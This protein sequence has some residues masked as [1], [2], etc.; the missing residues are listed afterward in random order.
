MTIYDRIKL[1]REQQGMSQQTLAEKVGFKTA[2][3]INKIELGLR[4][5]NQNKVIAF[6]KALNTTPS[7][8]MGWDEKV[9]RLLKGAIDFLEKDIELHNAI[10]ERYGEDILYIIDKY[11]ASDRNQ[12]TSMYIFAD[13]SEHSKNL[14]LKY[15][16]LDERAKKLVENIILSEYD[17]LYKKA[18]KDISHNPN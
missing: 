9:E 14:F 4:D 17:S 15:S 2:S 12:K 6:A 3:A 8:L 11:D 16:L 10:K 1:L 7:Y 13:E 18:D 5:I